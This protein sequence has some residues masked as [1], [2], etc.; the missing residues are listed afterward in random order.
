MPDDYNQIAFQMLLSDA[1]LALTF[2]ELAASHRDR[3][4]VERTIRN[5]IGA[6]N[7]IVAQHRTIPLSAENAAILDSKLKEIKKALI[8]LGELIE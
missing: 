5:A 1:D 8:E 2:V 6:Y 7:S 4:T 3:D